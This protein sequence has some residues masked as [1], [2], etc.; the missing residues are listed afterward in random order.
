MKKII[1]VLATLL[2]VSTPL[3]AFAEAPL[4]LQ[5]DANAEAQKH[6]EEGILHFN[7]GH[8]D[9][10]LK[11]FEVSEKAQRTAEVYFNEALVFDKMGK[12]GQATTHFKEAK[13]LANGN[14]KILDSEI[15]NGH[16]KNH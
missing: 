5:A 10:A 3:F 8:F 2:F 11:H 13:T 1:L 12:H 15:L 6:N 9:V 14:S 7:K 4:S 16:L